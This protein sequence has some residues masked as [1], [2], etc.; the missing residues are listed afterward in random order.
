MDT[1]IFTRKELYDL[2]WFEP[3][4]ALSNKYKISG[5]G[6]RKICV[7]MSI[8][9]PRAGHWQNLRAGK[10]AEKI[11]L[12]VNYKG[13]TEITLS[14]RGSGDLHHAEGNAVP[15]KHED[16][17]PATGIK[18]IVPARL[19]STDRRI[20]AARESLTEKRRYVRS[21]LVNTSRG[22]LDIKVAPVNVTRALRFMDA[23]IKAVESRGHKVEIDNDTHIVVQ[24]E[25]MKICLRERLKKGAGR[26][27]W[28][29]P[30]DLPTGMFYLKLDSY[31]RK[32]WKDGRLTL[33][34]QLPGIVTRLEIQ[35]KELL[36]EQLK[37]KK[38]RMQREEQERIERELQEQKE[39]QLLDFKR[40]L[41]KAS[42]W[43][44]TIM[45]R[46]YID[47][48]EKNAIADNTV[49]EELSSW[50]AWARDKADWYDPQ[51]EKEDEWLKDVD[52]ESLSFKKKPGYF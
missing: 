35:G 12:P 31:P 48:K 24:D 47:A 9:L 20:I 14:L 28:G 27:E 50:L 38:I 26:T 11:A 2:V 23:L 49:S 3:L 51:I 33:E 46:S 19:T 45:L 7:R 30:E 29:S 42:R 34:A 41:Q 22:Q 10:P 32:E 15:R 21:G 1:K 16:L 18:L 8:P 25:R 37:W 43:Q 5:T 40:L 4:S 6:L 39:K 36:E 52:K 44:R 13:E 17:K